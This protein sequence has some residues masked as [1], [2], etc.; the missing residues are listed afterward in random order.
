MQSIL[1]AILFGSLLPVAACNNN[2]QQE[3]KPEVET[4]QSYVAQRLAGYAPVKLT[5][6]LS[7]LTEKE[8]QMI[9]LLIE[10]AKIMDDLY[11]Q[12]SFGNKDSL[13]NSIKD[14]AAREFARINYGPWDKLNS[15]TPFIAGFGA[16]PHGAEFYPHDMTKDELEKSSAKDKH[17][18]YSVIRRD[19]TGK[20]ISIPYHQFYQEPLKRASDLLLQAAALA[21]DAGLKKYLELRAQ[22]LITDNYM[23]SDIAWMDMKNNGLDVIIGPIENYE[24]QLYNSRNA[25]EAYILVKDKEWSKK[26]EKYVSMLPELQKGLPVDEKY[27]SEKPGTSSQLNAY[28]VIYYAGHNNSGGKTIAVNLPNNEEV[29]KSKGTRRSQLKNAMRAKFDQILM[30]IAKELIDP[31]QLAQVQFDAFFADVMF[32]EVSHGLG[33]KNTVN[34]KG[35]VR[36]ALQEQGSWLEEAKADILGLYMVTKLVEMNELPGPIENYYTTFMAGILRSVRFGAGE[37]HGKANMLAFNFFEEKGAFAKTKDGHYKV[38][39]AKFR[40]AMNE[41]GKLILTLQGDGD[42]AAVEKLM[43]EKAV[44]RPD[45]QADLNRLQKAGIPVDILFE[46]G[47]GVLGLK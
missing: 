17:G 27:K 40:D 14:S 22:A 4:G 47:V 29:Q 42:K 23:P 35:T 7:S 5:A 9:P 20:L 25:F 33:I 8:K 45:L 13:L 26:L 41:L 31:S 30:P 28:D 43:K 15:D 12:Q 19:S 44:V 6:D 39:V 36:T 46:Q 16:K 2:D 10:A 21:E 1:K 18:E 3:K 32:H 24:D 11:W 34:G 37:A 38:D